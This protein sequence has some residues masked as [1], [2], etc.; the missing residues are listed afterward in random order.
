MKYLSEYRNSAAMKR[1]A[2]AIRREA[3]GLGRS[4]NIMEVCGTHTM[5]I[6]R[7]GIRKMLPGS[8]KLLSGPGCPVCVTPGGYLDRAIEFSRLPGTVIATFGDMVRVPGSYSSLEK[9]HAAGNNIRVVYSPLESLDL[10][11]RFPDKKIIFLGVGFETTSP[12]AAIS[13]KEAGKRGIKNFYIFSGHKRILPAMEL[14]LK[15]EE[16]KIDAFIC[17]GHVS[18]V[19]GSRPYEFIPEKH[20]VSCVVSGFEPLDILQSILMVIR[21]MAKGEKPRVENQYRRVVREK[22]N[23]RALALLSEVFEEADTEWRG[24]GTIE[25]SGLVLKKTYGDYD[26]LKEFP[27]KVKKTGED[28][29]CICGDILRGIKNPA[30][31]ILFGRECNPENPAGPCMVSSEGT[32]AAFYRYGNGR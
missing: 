8:I 21:I 14:L 24:I 22:G 5:A 7:Y 12:A 3:E 17:P 29:R 32:C 27:V 9:E 13:L 10:A 23:R 31:C 28:K 18:A 15:S 1:L 2:G 26:A 16:V 30:D 25:K 4:V 6:G 11:E 19:I 20:N